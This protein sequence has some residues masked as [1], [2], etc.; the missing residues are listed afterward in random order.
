[1]KFSKTFTRAALTLAIVMLSGPVVAGSLMDDAKAPKQK[2][3]VLEYLGALQ[4]G[5]TR[6]IGKFLNSG[7]DPNRSVIGDSLIPIKIVTETAPNPL[8]AIDLLIKHGAKM[9]GTGLLLGSMAHLK[10][11][12]VTGLV[13]RGADPNDWTQYGSARGSNPPLTLAVMLKKTDLV[14]AL[15]EAGADPNLVNNQLDFA[16]PAHIY[17]VSGDSPEILRLLLRHEADPDLKSRQGMSGLQMARVTNRP[18]LEAIL[19]EAG[20]TDDEPA[21]VRAARR[22]ELDALRSMLADGADPNA[23]GAVVEARAL[24]YA[25]NRGNV[26][27]VEALLKA[28]AETTY[29]SASGEDQDMLEWAAAQKHEN[30]DAIVAL[31]LGHSAGE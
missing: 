30:S 29:T 15:L 31:M 9:K 25:I 6:K 19:L 10:P 13:G 27:V 8:P 7:I 21:V 18:S 12:L 28:G 14:G 3:R 4:K 20:A 22:G 2:V 16:L 26:D 11:E 23:Q 5:D 17:A 24:V 1:M